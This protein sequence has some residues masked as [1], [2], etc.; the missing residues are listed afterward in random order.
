[1]PPVKGV[2]QSC[3]NLAFL[4][5]A[6]T[7]PPAPAPSGPLVPVA[8]GMPLSPDPMVLQQQ[9]Q[10]QQQALLSQQLQQQQSMQQQ[11]STGV[12]PG[13]NENG[14]VCPPV[15]P[16]LTSPCAPQPKCACHLVWQ[17]YFGHHGSY[18]F[19]LFCVMF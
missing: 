13:N 5:Q 19:L 15:V 7:P 11:L 1:M 2:P 17:G 4:A 10:L 6:G 9:Q 18:F 8:A 16:C 12:L 14:C 3:E